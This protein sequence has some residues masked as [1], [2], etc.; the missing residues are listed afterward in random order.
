MLGFRET[1]DSGKLQ[2]LTYDTTFPLGDFYFSILLFRETE[3]DES[4]VVPLAYMIHELKKQY[5]HLVCWSHMHEALGDLPFDNIIIVTDQE[6]AITQS[7]AI[8]L[9][10]LP[11]FL[12]WN[13]VQQD[14][15]CWLNNHGVTNSTE[16]RTILVASVSFLDATRKRH[17]RT[18]Q[19]TLCQ[20]GVSLSLNTLQH[21]YTRSSN[22]LARGTFVAEPPSLRY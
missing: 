7:I 8:T 19:L 6:A 10:S 20:N 16:M 9:R 4:P 21:T 13:H 12:C 15:R 17:T 18:F 22:I 2:Q 5:T 14:C 3:L 11:R 1:L